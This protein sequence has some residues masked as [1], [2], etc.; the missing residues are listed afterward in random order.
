MNKIV[1]FESNMEHEVAELICLKCLHRWIGVYPTTTLLKNIE[2]KCGEVG[3]VIKT[4]QT[5]L[6]EKGEIL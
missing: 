3:Y 4:G 2:C 5:V 6:N 1:E